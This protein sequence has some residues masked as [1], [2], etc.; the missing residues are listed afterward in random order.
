[1]IETEPAAGTTMVP[2]DDDPAS[3]EVA[4]GIYPKASSKGTFQYHKTVSLRA[5]RAA[6]AKTFG[7]QNLELDRRV[8]FIHGVFSSTNLPAS[9]ASLG[10]IPGH[11]TLPIACGEIKRIEK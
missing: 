10:P 5:L 9:V 8:V 3:M 11:V 6:F 4:T 7:N 1:L 2:F